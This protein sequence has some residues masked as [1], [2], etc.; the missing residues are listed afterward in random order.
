MTYK[1]IALDMDGTLLNSEHNVSQGN[2]DAIQAALAKGVIVTLATGRGIQ[3]IKPFI[4]ELAL[5]GPIVSV[6]GG[7]I[8]KNENEL[9]QQYTLDRGHLQALR[10][11]AEQH[12][13]W[14][15]GYSS[16]GACQKDTFIAKPDQVDWYKFGY[17][18][19]D[20]EARTAILST[21][22]E[23]GCFEVSNSHP[24]NIEVNPKDI[25]KANGLRALCHEKGLAMDEV[26]AVGD[27][28]NDIHMIKEAGLGVA[29]GN[30]QEVVK[31]AADIVTLTND[32]DG[33]A[34]V[35]HD[36]VL[37]VSSTK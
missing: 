2:R 12:N 28:L 31:K 11:L 21:L 29:M 34:K 17:H 3:S 1:M 18:V 35:I 23:W 6:N 14:Y 27:S 8:W 26:I 24:H 37:D 22:D 33:V 30:A 9:W 4:K 36:Y 25:H 32:E 15:W 10:E 13:A 20:D 7:M 16:E 19:E 5:P